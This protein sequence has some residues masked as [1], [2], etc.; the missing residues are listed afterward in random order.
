VSIRPRMQLLVGIL[1]EFKRPERE[2][3]H[4]PPPGDEVTNDWSYMP[5]WCEGG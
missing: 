1:K 3:G 4:S 5:L 2:V